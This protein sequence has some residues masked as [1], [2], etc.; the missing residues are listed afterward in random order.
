MNKINILT[1]I[2]RLIVP[3]R[4]WSNECGNALQN[5][6]E[7]LNL[8]FL[9]FDKIKDD[10][11]FLF[12]VGVGNLT[13]Y[14]GI[15]DESDKVEL[16]FLDSI[17]EKIKDLIRDNNGYILINYLHEGHIKHENYKELHNE[18]FKHKIP[19]NKVFFSIK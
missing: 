12:P 1:K 19:A 7:K 14:L 2:P 9:K 6:E 13:E 18:L 5:T 10:T 17:D 3:S 8:N 16:S 11:I 15:S 4:G